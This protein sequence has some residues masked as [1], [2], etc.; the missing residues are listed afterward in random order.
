M[1]IEEAKQLIKECQEYIRSYDDYE[2]NTMKQNAIKL[3]AEY[4]N[5]SAVAA[6]LNEKGYR[7]PG[8]L[9]AGKRGKVKLTSNDVTKMIDSDINSDDLLHPIV[10][11][12]LNQNRRRKGIVT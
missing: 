4:E 2:P 3:Y 1:K 10:K 11:K 5:V 7:M 6:A 8:K 12:A 9:V